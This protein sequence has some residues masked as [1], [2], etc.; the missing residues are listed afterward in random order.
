M[1][2][3][4]RL[5]DLDDCLLIVID[6][7]ESFLR[8]LPEVES[9][10]LVNRI[11]WLVQVA[12]KLHVP[13]IGTVEDMAKLGGLVSSIAEKLPAG[14]AVYDKMIFGLADQPDILAAVARTGRKTAVLVGLETDVCIAHS[15]LGLLQ[16]GYNVVAVSDATASPDSGQAIGGQM[17]GLE[18]MRR[19]GVLLVT[20]KSLYYEWLRTVTA[21][22]EFRANF[23]REIRLPKGVNL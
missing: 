14:T 8:K 11:G 1:S 23:E 7:Q 5:I 4:N 9:E 21:D 3:C 19:A 22:D 20:V 18:R 6:V 17:I 12:D 13:V 16:Q 2:L 15:A 10:L